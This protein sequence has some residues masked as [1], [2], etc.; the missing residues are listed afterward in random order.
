MQAIS[1]PAD[2]GSMTRLQALLARTALG[3]KVNEAAV[4]TATS[5]ETIVAI[6]LDKARVKFSTRMKVRAAYEQAGITFHNDGI[7]IRYRPPKA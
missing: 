2:T 5:H 3:L 7:N 4:L 6:E 1:F